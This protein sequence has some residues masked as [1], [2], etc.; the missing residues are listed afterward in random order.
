MTHCNICDPK[1]KY[2]DC[3]CSENFLSFIKTYDDFNNCKNYEKFNII[4]PWTLS[5]I[6]ACCNFNSKID[7]KKYKDFY[8]KELNVKN[9]YN[10][11]STYITIKYQTR[12]R[13]AIR[14]FANGKIGMA[15]VL[16]IKSLTYAVRKIFK[17]L[18]SLLAFESSSFITDLKICMINSDFKID[19]NI[20]Q[21]NL[22]KI[23]DENKLQF[24]KR[25]SF[26]PN[27]YPAINVKVI[28]PYDGKLTTCA[29][30][31]SGSIMITGGT[32]IRVYKFISNEILNIL[33]NSDNIIYLE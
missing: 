22:C 8:C 16:N 9:F 4:K 32:D 19:R 27:K 33:E 17:R 29:I 6:T 2:K 11:L 21:C 28:S 30:F 3:I 14:I 23:F 7:V 24:V 10:C 1:F 15:G 26:D 13:I 5:T 20:K 18:T 12:K 25:Y 31:R